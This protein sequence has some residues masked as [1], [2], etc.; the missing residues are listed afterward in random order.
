MSLWQVS[1]S[2]LGK[3]GYLQQLE[4]CSNGSKISLVLGK[5]CFQLPLGPVIQRIRQKPHS[6]R[7]DSQ[8]IADK[9][10]LVNVLEATA[11]PGKPNLS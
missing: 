11:Q 8:E 1:G 7:V 9:Y 3:S 6:N 5:Q 4:E 10:D 2:P